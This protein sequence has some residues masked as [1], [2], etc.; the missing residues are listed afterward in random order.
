MAKKVQEE[1]LFLSVPATRFNLDF[2]KYIQGRKTAGNSKPAIFLPCSS[3]VLWNPS[4][5]LNFNFFDNLRAIF[6]KNRK[7]DI[8][9]TNINALGIRK[10]CADCFN[11]RRTVH[12]CTVISVQKYRNESV[13]CRSPAVRAECPYCNAQMNIKNTELKSAFI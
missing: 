10:G 12:F 7:L 3:A 1:R 9:P 8:R 13:A 2:Y 11:N 4:L 6:I 5:S